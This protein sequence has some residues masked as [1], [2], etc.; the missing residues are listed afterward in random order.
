M[1]AP[2]K[3]K[4]HASSMKCCV[5]QNTPAVAFWPHI[6]PD[7]PS[8]PYCRAC[9]DAAQLSILQKMQVAGIFT[10]NF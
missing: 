4:V 6:D 3:T 7:I 9:L 10:E 5:C 2:T 1:P 8:H